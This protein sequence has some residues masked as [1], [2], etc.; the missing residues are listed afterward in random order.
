MSTGDTPVPG[1]AS[2][3]PFNS[4]LGCQSPLFYREQGAPVREKPFFHRDTTHQYEK[5]FPK[6]RE[7][8]L[9]H[10]EK[11]IELWEEFLVHREKII[12]LWEE[13][14]VHREKIIELW[15][16]FLQHREVFPELE[17]LFP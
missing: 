1:K 12:E 14:L 2:L 15:E 13:F 7:E 8:F 3:H 16:M 9:V 10:R 4:I 11:I 6:H 5:I 17:K